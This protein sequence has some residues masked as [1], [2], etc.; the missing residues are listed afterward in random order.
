MMISKYHGQEK[1]KQEKIKIKI[2]KSIKM[3]SEYVKI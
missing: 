1:V 3:L 2:L